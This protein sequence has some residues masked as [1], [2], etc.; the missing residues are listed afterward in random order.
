MAPYERVRRVIRGTDNPTER[1][2]RFVALLTASLPKKRTR[3]VLSGGSAIE[4]YLSGA[5]TTGDM[6]IIYDIKGLER[7]LKQ[8][9]FERS[10]RSWINDELGLAVDAVGDSLSGS[11]DKTTTIVTSFGPAT[12]I[13]KEDLILKRLASAKHWKYP[14]DIEQAYLLAKAYEDEVDWNYVDERAK[15]QGTSDY[16]SRLRRMLKRGFA[17]RVGTGSPRRR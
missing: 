11:Y 13:G 5:L 4:V 17:R 2:V 16:L 7:L 14:S 8:W 15:E 3:P 1:K 9:H 10:F 6:D 12:V